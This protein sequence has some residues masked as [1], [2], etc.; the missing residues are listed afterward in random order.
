[1]QKKKKGNEHFNNTWYFGLIWGM[2][3]TAHIKKPW[4]WFQL[5]LHMWHYDIGVGGI[6]VFASWKSIMFSLLQTFI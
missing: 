6:F 1:M 2:C 4:D 5:G 3:N